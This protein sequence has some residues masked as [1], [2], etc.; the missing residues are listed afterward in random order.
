MRA[1]TS[2]SSFIKAL[3]EIFYPRYSSTGH[4]VRMIED[5]SILSIETFFQDIFRFAEK[6]HGGE[7]T[8]G[9]SDHEGIAAVGTALK[10]VVLSILPQK[11]GKDVQ[12]AAHFAVRNISR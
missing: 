1:I 10:R 5:G 3:S 6:Q 9:F 7:T 4:T 8:W 11:T 2:Y 12:H